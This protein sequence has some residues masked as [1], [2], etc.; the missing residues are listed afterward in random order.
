LTDLQIVDL[1][2]KRNADAIRYSTEKYGGY[3]HSV[4]KNILSDF[5]DAQECVNDTW[6]GAWNSMPD[7]RPRDL[8]AF[9]GMITRR[10]ACSR[11]RR[12]Y[13]QKRGSGQLPLILE[14][15]DS[16]LPTS[17]SAAQIVEAKQLEEAVNAFLH[18]LPEQD[19]NIFL[20]RYWY[21][22]SIAQISRRYDILP[23]TIKSSLYRS[24]RKLR[25]YLEKEDLL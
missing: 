10:L 2:W 23:N 3:C 6:I 8:R 11:L 5:Q 24:R 15:L 21:A 13:A 14:E 17:P 18:T 20:R 1:Y 19:C 7:H 22:E 25:A 4:A 9:L 12:D 16:C